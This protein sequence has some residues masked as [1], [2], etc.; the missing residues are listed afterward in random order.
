LNRICGRKDQKITKILDFLSK[1]FQND[2][3]S[4]K[5]LLNWDWRENEEVKEWMGKNNF[6]VDWF[7]E[8]SEGS[9]EQC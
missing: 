8:D 2:W 4:L 3:D 6:Y 7:E 1:V 9:N 5:K